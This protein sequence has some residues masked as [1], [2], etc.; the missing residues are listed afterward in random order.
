MGGCWAFGCSNRSEQGFSMYR[1][2]TDQQRRAVWI[3]KVGRLDDSSTTKLKEPT[4]RA[5]LCEVRV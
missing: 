1:F 5:L 2:P 4:P 3:Q